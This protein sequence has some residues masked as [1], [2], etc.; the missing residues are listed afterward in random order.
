MY[1]NQTIE[2]YI[3]FVIS[4]FNSTSLQND[5]RGMDDR[6]L[7]SSFQGQ[8]LV[9]SKVYT[10]CDVNAEFLIVAKNKEEKPI[11]KGN[12][13][14][15]INGNLH[16]AIELTRDSEDVQGH[17]TRFLPGEKYS[18]AEFKDYRV[19]DCVSRESGPSKREYAKMTQEEA[20]K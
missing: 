1:E 9:E 10:G 12:A 4:K 15:R 17:V 18:F 11:Y 20:N 8:F 14:F 16:W 3:K 2:D 19:L 5:T 13:D 6:L 7:E